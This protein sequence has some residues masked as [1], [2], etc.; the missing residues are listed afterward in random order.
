MHYGYDLLKKQ[1]YVV[2]PTLQNREP[3]ALIFP[4]S[5]Y[6]FPPICQNHVH[7]KYPAAERKDAAYK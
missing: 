5:L 1:Q 4:V 2:V 6:T 7:K 3:C